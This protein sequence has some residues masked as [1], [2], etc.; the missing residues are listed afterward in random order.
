MA[1]RLF[2]IL[3]TEKIDQIKKSILTFQQSLKSMLRAK[4]SWDKRNVSNEIKN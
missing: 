3:L 4:L 1:E 2:P